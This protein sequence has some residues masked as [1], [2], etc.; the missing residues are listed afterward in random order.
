[1][2]T[3]TRG[4]YDLK[5]ASGKVVKRDGRTPEEAMQLQRD[6]WPDDPVIAWREHTEPIVFGIPQISE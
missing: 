2:N 5:L 4:P 3:H 1:M 6:L